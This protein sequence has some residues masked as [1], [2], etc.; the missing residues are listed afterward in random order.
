LIGYR[1]ASQLEITS[2]TEVDVFLVMVGTTPKF[3][4]Y[5]YN[6]LKGNNPVK[7]EKKNCTIVELRR[8]NIFLPLVN[9]ELN[10]GE[11]FSK[12]WFT[13]SICPSIWGW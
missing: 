8:A 3:G 7:H 2:A 1:W 13:L 12:H 6:A 5:P 11:T 4:S 10:S 9:P